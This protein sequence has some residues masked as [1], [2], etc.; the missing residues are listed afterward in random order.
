[1]SFDPGLV[2]LA[3]VILVALVLF[4]YTALRGWR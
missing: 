3:I 4:G 2:L 1:M